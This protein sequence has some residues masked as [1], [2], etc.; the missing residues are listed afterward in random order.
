MIIVG[1][2]IVF[3]IFHE[4]LIELMESKNGASHNPFSF[5]D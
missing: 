1:D 4:C 5:N 2:V 3:I